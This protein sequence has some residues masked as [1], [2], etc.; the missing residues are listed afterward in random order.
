MDWILDFLCQSETFSAVAGARLDFEFAEKTCFLTCLL[1]L[2]LCEVKQESDC[3]CHA[4]TG[5]RADSYY[6]IAK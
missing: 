4:G 3:L 6:K 5:S 2:Y 1:D